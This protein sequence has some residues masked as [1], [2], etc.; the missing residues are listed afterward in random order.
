MVDE[1]LYGRVGEEEFVVDNEAVVNISVV[2][3]VEG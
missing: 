1:G 3:E 2:G